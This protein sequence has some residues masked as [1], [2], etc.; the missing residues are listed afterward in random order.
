MTVL[1]SI[2]VFRKH[3]SIVN[4]KQKEYKTIFSFNNTNKMFRKI[5][6]NLNVP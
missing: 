1:A 6:K 3:P 5:F 2:N 4:M